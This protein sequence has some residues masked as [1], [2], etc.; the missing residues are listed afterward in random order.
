[1]EIPG[2][3]NSNPGIPIPGFSKISRDFLGSQKIPKN[4]EFLRNFF[5]HSKNKKNEKKYIYDLE[6]FLN[7]IVHHLYRRVF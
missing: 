4:S 2:I 5:F 3:L 6:N 7:G 1:M